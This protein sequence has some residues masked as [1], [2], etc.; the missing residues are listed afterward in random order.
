MRNSLKR[1]TALFENNHICIV[2]AGDDKSLNTPANASEI[3]NNCLRKVLAPGSDSIQTVWEKG[4]TLC[5]A[6]FYN[7]CYRKPAFFLERESHLSITVY[8]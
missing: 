1:Y 7:S 6:S 2:H 3:L 5:R 4:L 8:L